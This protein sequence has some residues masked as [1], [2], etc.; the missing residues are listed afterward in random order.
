MVLSFIKIG[1]SKPM[2]FLFS[3]L[4]LFISLNATA[5]SNW[6]DAIKQIQKKVR[7]QK[8]N[9]AL[10]ILERID[11]SAMPD[12]I[13][14]KIFYTKSVLHELN[15][16]RMGS[17][18]KLEEA[19]AEFPNDYFIFHSLA[20]LCCNTG[21]NQKAREYVK[22]SFVKSQDWNDT[23]NTFLTL[24]GVYMNEG[25]WDSMIAINRSIVEK[26]SNW[27]M[28]CY[29]NISVAYIMTKQP[30]KGIPLL[31]KVLA[32]NSMP[33]YTTNNNLGMMYT[34]V[35]AYKKAIKAFETAIEIEPSFAYPYSNLGF[36]YHKLKQYDKAIELYNKSIKLGPTNS[37]VYKNK[38]LTY[39]ALNMNKEACEYLDESKRKGYEAFYGQEV[40]ELIEK[41]CKD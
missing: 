30:Q 6:D 17:I 16:N 24:S 33:D 26:D 34:D 41:H 37:W 2:K 23:A 31:E 1:I 38:A 32:S 29:N 21:L 10:V 19:A 20:V 36:A 40:N 5:Q 14:K 12:S 4:V 39:L 13:K 25:K 18:E 9:D 8:Y 3:F 22:L 7:A 35:G 28:E 11:Q 15:K 27:M